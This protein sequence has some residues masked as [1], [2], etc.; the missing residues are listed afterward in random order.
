M[1]DVS[2]CVPEAVQ[3]GPLAPDQV[4]PNQEKR[5]LMRSR[6]FEERGSLLR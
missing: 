2:A 4:E 6:K 1:F 3:F 5:D